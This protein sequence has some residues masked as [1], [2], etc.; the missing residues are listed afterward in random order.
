MTHGIWGMACFNG[1]SA[2]Q[3][4]FVVEEGYLPFGYK[5]EGTCKRG[6]EIGIETWDDTKPG[7]RFYCRPC[8]IA[9]LEAGRCDCHVG[10]GEGAWRETHDYDCATLRTLRSFA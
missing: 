1:L 9:F 3:Q 2:D 10:S 4:R 5:P 7:P 8:A 6:A